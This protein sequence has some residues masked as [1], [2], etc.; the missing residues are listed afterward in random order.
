MV[1]QHWE[2]HRQNTG[3]LQEKHAK[4]RPASKIQI[5]L[6]GRLIQLDIS[7]LDIST[8]VNCYVKK[9]KTCVPKNQCTYQAA[10]G[11]L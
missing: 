7:D 10:K 3:S 4:T 2:K 1:H 11:T 5:L 6:G 8:V 9:V